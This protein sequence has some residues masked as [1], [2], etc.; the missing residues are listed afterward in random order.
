MDESSI[1]EPTKKAL[2]VV[3]STTSSV[4]ERASEDDVRGLQAYTIRKMDR[5]MPTGKDID[6]YKLLSV[7]E[8]PLHNRQKYLNVLY[9]L[10]LFPT[11]CYGKFHSQAVRLTF[12]EYIQ[13]K[14]DEK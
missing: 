2:E 14:V 6:H 13:V 4:L 11:G 10:S 12:S 1:D 3:S 7:S 9:F 8:K 5:Y